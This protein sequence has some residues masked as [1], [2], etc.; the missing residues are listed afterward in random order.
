MWGKEADLYIWIINKNSCNVLEAKNKMSFLWY[1]L[2]I[3]LL[4]LLQCSSGWCFAIHSIILPLAWSEGWWTARIHGISE[5]MGCTLICWLASKNCH[6]CFLLSIC[7]ELVSST[8]S[9]SL[10]FFGCDFTKD[11]AQNKLHAQSAGLAKCLF[12]AMWK[13]WKMMRKWWEN[14]YLTCWQIL[15]V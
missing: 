15:K 1:S 5:E 6:S 3:Y 9:D 4:L 12:K 10:Y 2:F 7:G 13:W 14:S 8:H 11:K